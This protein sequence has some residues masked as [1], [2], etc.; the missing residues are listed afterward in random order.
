MIEDF[1]Y[2]S[3]YFD[4][5]GQNQS[6][7]IW[8]RGDRRTYEVVLNVGVYASGTIR[9][10]QDDGGTVW[11]VLAV[12]TIRKERKTAISQSTRSVVGFLPACT[13]SSVGI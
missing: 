5:H 8:I 7:K 2:L 4:L 11:L 6:S 12:Y 13:K 10:E 9:D 1:F 3:N